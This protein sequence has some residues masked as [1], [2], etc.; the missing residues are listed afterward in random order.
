[1]PVCSPLKPSMLR[2]PADD[3][4]N[5]NLLREV[6]LPDNLVGSLRNCLYNNHS[7]LLSILSTCDALSRLLLLLPLLATQ[8]SAR[9]NAPLVI[10][11]KMSPTLVHILSISLV[12]PTIVQCNTL[13]VLCPR[14]LIGMGVN[15]TGTLGGRRSSAENAR[16]EAP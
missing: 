11:Y 2:S 4:A 14:Q 16:I 10:C 12:R 9:G 15:A 5:P 6:L 7:P 8:R 13:V 1:M 3:S